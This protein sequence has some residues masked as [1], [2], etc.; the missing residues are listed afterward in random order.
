MLP[1]M[2]APFL[3]AAV[4]AFPPSS[5][6]MAE[7]AART[8]VPFVDDR[9][10]SSSVR[11]YVHGRSVQIP[12]RIH[13]LELD[14]GKLRIQSSSWAAIQCLCT[15]GTDGYMRQASL[16]RVLG[17]NESWAIPFVVLLAGEYVVEIIDDIVASLS[18]LDRD[19][20][21]NFARENRPMMRRLR[22]KASSYWN[23]YYRRSHPDR[24]TYPGLAFLHQLEVWAS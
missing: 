2:R 14:E 10:R 6:T 22:S 16:R 15:R 3:K 13:F 24:S 4:A 21:A 20:Y 9:Y 19:A 1:P 11:A 12:T 18:T 7:D 23:V 8:L 5:R 17:F